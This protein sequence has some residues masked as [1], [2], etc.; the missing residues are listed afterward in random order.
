MPARTPL[1]PPAYQDYFRTLH[2]LLDTVEQDEGGPIEAAARRI[3]T[4]LS[5]HKRVVLFGTGHSYLLALELCGRAGGL[6]GI[7]II[8]DATLSMAEGLSKSTAAERLGGY[9]EMLVREAGLSAGDVLLVISNSGRNAVPVE[10]LAT[11]RAL[12]VHTIALTSL[13]H[14]QS[15]GPRPPA[16]GRLFEYAD[17]VLDNHGAPGDACVDLPRVAHAVGPTSTVVGAAILQA[18]ALRAT[19]LLA[20]SGHP[21]DVY[22]SANVDTMTAP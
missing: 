15:T 9:G 14:S 16:P 8:H 5:D 22:L 7:E 11:A 3:A 13:A 21:P 17:I 12:G 2:N 19:E 20:A 18:V 6:T 1:S 4:A 10:A